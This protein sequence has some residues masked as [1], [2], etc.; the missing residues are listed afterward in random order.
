M[1]YYG[2]T[3]QKILQA[4]ESY[5]GSGSDQ[6]LQIAQYGMA[7]DNAA[8][9]LN[10]V[11]NVHTTLN[12]NGNVVAWSYGL[13]STSM[14]A[15]EAAAA[16]TANAINSNAVTSAAVKEQIKI[17]LNASVNSTTHELEAV[18]GATKAAT[19]TRAMTAAA[20]IAT[21]VVGCGIGLKLGVWVDGALYN[22]NPDF[23]DSHNLSELNPEVWKN[24]PISNALLKN[25]GYDRFF[26]L[27]D[28]N[29]QMYCDENLYAIYA[30]YLNNSGA[31]NREA[32]NRDNIPD[33][34]FNDPTIVPMDVFTYTNPVGLMWTRTATPPQEVTISV[35]NHTAD[36]LF[37]SV[38]VNTFL[39]VSDEPF[40]LT[41][42]LNGSTSVFNSQGITEHG[43][44][45]YF[46]DFIDY[47]IDSASQ[48]TFITNN[49]ACPLGDIRTILAFGD[50]TGGQPEGFNT[51][52]TMPVIPPGSTLPD[53]LNLLKQQY[54][55]IWADQLDIGTLNDDGTITQHHYIPFVMP[56]GGTDPQPESSP[57]DR[58]GTDPGDKP[59]PKPKQQERIKEGT[60]PEDP[61]QPTDEDKGT[62]NTP[63]IVPPTGTASALYKIYNPTE[64]QVQSFG[65]W[66]WSPSFV[67]QILKMFSDPMQAII[68]LHKIYATPHTGGT[69]NIKVGYLDSGVSSKY[70]DEQ[71]ITVDCGNVSVPEVFGCVYDYYTK[72]NLYL[73][74]VG[75]VPLNTADVMRGKV[76]VKY[77]VDVITGAVLVDV[78]ITRD[79]GAGG[80]LYQYT[81]SCAEQFPLSS[82]SYMGIATGLLGIAAGVAGT[83]ATGGAALPMVLG[84][85]AAA[86]GMHTEV[87]RANGFSGNS[88]AMGCKKPYIII[89]RPITARTSGDDHMVGYPSNAYMTVN[90]A[91]GFIK[92]REIFTDTV[93]YATDQERA[94]IRSMF[95][96]GVII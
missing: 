54:P 71:Y 35:T 24:Y 33:D 77:H 39:F 36:V 67:D 8:K 72:I 32:V 27:M 12:Q 73:P 28:E 57:D 20:H 82:G 2:T 17:P 81:G 95:K 4:V 1:A 22:I 88:G 6:W 89:E 86:G 23:W 41:R 79:G 90:S 74:F 16:T 5:Y 7:A 42:T 61:D 80:V 9:I 52:G 78:A 56:G 50:I 15:A 11:P 68:S 60:E 21:A 83:I 45:Y 44:T 55:D 14:S 3:Y 29:G 37:A 96:E 84:I 51:D 76:N 25:S 64:A 49:V 62:G 59:N 13:E 43:K 92:A 40:T 66:L 58:P 34:Y 94:E 31:F 10:Q 69:A 48:L 91:K 53:I 30:Q 93:N 87:Q 70:V 85:G 63:T 18:S 75:I 19:G 46:Y 38:N 47:G 26:C 65:A